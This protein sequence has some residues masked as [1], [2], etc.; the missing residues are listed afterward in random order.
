VTCTLD[1]AQAQQT[2]QITVEDNELLSEDC[3]DLTAATHTSSLGNSFNFYYSNN[4]ELDSSPD[5]VSFYAV[6]QGET[7]L[8]TFITF[9]SSGIVGSFDISS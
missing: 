9:S 8:P 2:L 7:S 3:R 1:S 4:A 6:E 5:S